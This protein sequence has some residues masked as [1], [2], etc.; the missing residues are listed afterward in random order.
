MNLQ[1][2]G[3]GSM[4][5]VRLPYFCTNSVVPCCA[6]ALSAFSLNHW[7][8]EMFYFVCLG[9]NWSISSHFCLVLNVEHFSN[10][11]LFSLWQLWLRQLIYWSFIYSWQRYVS[12]RAL[13]RA[14]DTWSNAERAVLPREVWWNPW[15][16][17]TCRFLLLL[18]LLLF[19]TNCTPSGKEKSRWTNQLCPAV[20]KY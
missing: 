17:V 7:I 9:M 13:F 11:L 2:F 3:E 20:K 1:Q 14:R 8:S 19:E 18:L 12:R 6:W 10:L 15:W 4:L 16:W 5:T